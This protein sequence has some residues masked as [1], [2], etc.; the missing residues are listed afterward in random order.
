MS[1]Q[2]AQFVQAVVFTLLDD[3][4]KKK[5]YYG[6][7]VEQVREIRLLENITSVPK[8]PHYVRGVMNL[9]GQIIPVIDLKAKL[10]FSERTENKQSER[11]LVAD[12]GGLV[13]GF[14]VDE[15]DQVIRMPLSEVESLQSEILESAPYVKGMAKI[16][17]KLIVLLDLQK[18]L[19]EQ[20]TLQKFE[21]EVQD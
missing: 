10:G 9:R 8:S 7:G 20:G 2:R 17:G 4:S 18:L 1:E 19:Q 5:E 12:S 13:A 21:G 3:A 15:V 16:Q 14:L 6:V 11:I